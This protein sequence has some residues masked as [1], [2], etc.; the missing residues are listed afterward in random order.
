MNGCCQTWVT[1]KLTVEQLNCYHSLK[2]IPQYTVSDIQWVMTLPLMFSDY[3][4]TIWHKTS[5]CP[6]TWCEIIIWLRMLTSVFHDQWSLPYQLVS[7]ST[8]ERFS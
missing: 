5:S 8:A 1:A 3:C 4:P 2:S 6:V 7:T